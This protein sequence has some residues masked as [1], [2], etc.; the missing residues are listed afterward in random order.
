MYNQQLQTWQREAYEKYV[1]A[2]IN[3]PNSEKEL[4]EG[5]EKFIRGSDQ[6][7][8]L[9]LITMQK[10]TGGKLSEK[11]KKL[12]QSYRDQR[13]QGWDELVVRQQFL[14]YDIAQTEEE[15]KKFLGYICDEA[16]LVNKFDHTKPYQ[17]EHQRQGEKEEE[18]SKE[19]SF[20]KRINA[21]V[22]PEIFKKDLLADLERD[23]KNAK[24]SKND[25]YQQVSTHQHLL[26][27]MPLF[28]AHVVDFSIF[29]PKAV[30]DFAQRLASQN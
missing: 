22:K 24:A 2:L 8:F 10:L 7:D 23:A 14:D 16:I 20:Q 29:N 28:L 12:F 11:D 18:E 26:N 17:V 6:Y 4:V 30:L 15:R 5:L 1:N 27:S 25:D 21:T 3:T 13:R 19:A 9:Y